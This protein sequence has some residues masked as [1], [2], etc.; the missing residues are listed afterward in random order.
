MSGCKGALDEFVNAINSTSSITFGD[1][2]EGKVLGYGKVVITKVLSLDNVMLAESLGY[3]FL[4]IY[5]LANVG[6]DSYF[7]K[8]FMK[9]F[10]SDN[11]KLVRVGYV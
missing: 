4:S 5:H 8:H 9:V 3:N 2:S 11:L 6:Y 10:S 7:T 1:N